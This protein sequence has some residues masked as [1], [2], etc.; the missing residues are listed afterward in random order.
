MLKNFK[1]HEH[2]DELRDYSSRFNTDIQPLYNTERHGTGGPIYERWSMETAARKR[3]NGSLYIT[4]CWDW[5]V[6]ESREYRE[7]FHI[8]AYGR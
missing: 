8:I 3:I 5:C 7:A 4:Q 6:S 2:F 1:K